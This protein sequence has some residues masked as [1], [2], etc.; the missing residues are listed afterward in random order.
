MLKT[1]LWCA[2]FFLAVEAQAETPNIVFILVDDLGYMDVG[3]YNPN[4]FHETPN[5]DRLAASG[6]KF[7]T[8]CISNSPVCTP[9]RGILMSGQHPLYC[10]AIQNELQILPGHGKYFGEVLRDAG[11]RTGCLHVQ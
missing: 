10:D 8:H 6:M 9:Y 3:A 1:T 5:I 7:I 11:Y 2:A 4:T